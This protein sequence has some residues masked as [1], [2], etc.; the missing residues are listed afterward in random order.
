[1]AEIVRAGIISVD[2]GQTEAS[3]ALGMT[4]GQTMR[5]IVLPQAMRVIIPPTGNETISMLKYTSLV[6]VI[7]VA[8]LLYSVQLIYAQ[9]FQQI[10][11][12]LVACIWYLAMTTVLSIGQYFLERHYGRG[13]MRDEPTTLFEQIRSGWLGRRADPDEL[14]QRGAAESGGAR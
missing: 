13:R 1:M 6:S 12:L 2:E 5:Y 11:L 10:P 4:R 7:A 14:L 8:E 3:K 9:N